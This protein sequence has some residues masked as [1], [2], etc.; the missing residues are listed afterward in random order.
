VLG[1][2]PANL[3]LSCCVVSVAV[4][5]QSTAAADVP[6]MWSEG[7]LVKRFCLLKTTA[8][9]ALHAWECLVPVCLQQGRISSTRQAG[10]QLLTCCPICLAPSCDG[11]LCVLTAYRVGA[12]TL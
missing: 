12:P 8:Y 2:A 10:H 9:A 11:L 4:V 7:L 5:G 1:Y 6:V 3:T